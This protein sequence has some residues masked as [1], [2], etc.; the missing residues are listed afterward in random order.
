MGKKA[1]LVNIGGEGSPRWKLVE[2]KGNHED[3]PF[4]K[5]PERW[6]LRPEDPPGSLPPTFISDNAPYHM[7]NW[8]EALRS[9][10][11]PNAT[12][13]NGFDHSVACIM[14]ARAYRE[15]RKLYWNRQT[16]TISDQPQS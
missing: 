11:Q 7:T 13:E 14:A 9:R 12:V 1:T 5:R 2:E 10:K 15:G 8:L 3:N 4:L 16:E 6:V